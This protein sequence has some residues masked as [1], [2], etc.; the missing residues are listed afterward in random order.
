M[1]TNDKL[2]TFKNKYRDRVF[3]SH[4]KPNQ[5]HNILKRCDYG[6]IF[7]KNN[8]TNNV[9]SPVKVA[10]YLSAGLKVLIT[11]NVGDYSSIIV[12]NKLGFLVNNYNEYLLLNKPD[13]EE[14]E[15]LKNFANDYYSKNASN[16]MSRYL[17]F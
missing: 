11:S 13:L 2:E 9:S 16:L 14:K 12:E 17:S 5:V 10:E 15:R 6:I 8:V 3:M 7:R 1:P 4:V